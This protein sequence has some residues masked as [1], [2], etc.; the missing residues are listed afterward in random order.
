M[1]N[2]AGTS[3][4]PAPIYDAS[5]ESWDKAMH[6]NARSVFLGTKYATTQF[7]AQEP[8]HS[9]DRGWIISIASITALVG[10]RAIRKTG[11]NWI[12]RAVAPCS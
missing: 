6:T 2:N 12:R 4:P 10:C 5:E 7:S 11:T 3:P 1:V 9:G 8:R